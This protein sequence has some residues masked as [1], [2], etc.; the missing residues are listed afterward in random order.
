MDRRSLSKTNTELLVVITP[1]FVRAQAP[2]VNLPLP[3]YPK[4]FLDGSS[5]N[6]D[7][8]KFVGPRGRMDAEE[9]KK[10]QAPAKKQ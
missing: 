2:G 4:T 10:P 1:R 8:P 6:A 5:P 3:Q 7:Q 9:P